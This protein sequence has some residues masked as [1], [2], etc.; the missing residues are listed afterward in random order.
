MAEPMALRLHDNQPFQDQLGHA[1]HPSKAQSMVHLKCTVPLI[2]KHP[3][4]Y[5][6][7]EVWTVNAHRGRGKKKSKS[8]C[9]YFA[10]DLNNPNS[11]ET[12][13]ITVVEDG[14]VEF[15][16]SFNY[17]GSIITDDLEYSK[18]IDIRITI[19]TQAMGALNNY[20]KCKQAP[21]EAKRNIYLVIPINLAL[22]GVK[23]WD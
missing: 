7:T 19:A 6:C 9:M 12:G 23:S 22:W 20:F 10:A 15:T 13:P 5:Y 4:L 3:S 14:Q 2:F 17:L 11:S 1:V 18:D 16:E 8:K 21:L